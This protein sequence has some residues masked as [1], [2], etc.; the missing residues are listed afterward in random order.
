MNN[1]NISKGPFFHRPPLTSLLSPPPVGSLL[2]QVLLVGFFQAV[3]MTVL[4]QQQWFVPYMTLHNNVTG[5]STGD[6]VS[7]ENYAVFGMSMCQYIV[8]ALAYAK[9]RPFREIFAK[10]YWF[11]GALAA[12]T[13]F[14][15]YVLIGPDPVIERW[16]ELRMPPLDFRLVIFGLSVA[17]V[18]SP[19]MNFF[20]FL[21]NVNF[22]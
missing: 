8:L 3:S 16:L 21:I 2:I 20:F 1:L 14:S 19:F 4:T 10:N 9:G 5:L 7:H 11:V 18:I 12:S 6:Y 15:V 17:Q 13:A 22:F